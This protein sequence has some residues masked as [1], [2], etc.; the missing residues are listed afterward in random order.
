MSGGLTNNS[1]LGKKSLGKKGKM[2]GVMSQGDSDTNSVAKSE[3]IRYGHQ[4]THYEFKEGV[5]ESQ[6]SKHIQIQVQ[7]VQEEQKEEQKHE[8]S[9]AVQQLNKKPV[10]P[11]IKVP[12][13]Q[14]QLEAKDKI[15]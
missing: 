11:L 15:K 12:Q 9:S 1:L 5:N 4:E 10:V 8:I 13:K 7:D 14:E 6:I 2:L 3:S